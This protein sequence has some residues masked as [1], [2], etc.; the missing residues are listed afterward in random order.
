M[1][2]KPPW[3]PPDPPGPPGATSWPPCPPP[4]GPWPPSPPPPTPWPPAPWP[5]NPF[6]NYLASLVGHQVTVA[7][8]NGT[9]YTGLLTGV[10]SCYFITLLSCVDG[11]PSY[12][13]I[14]VQEIASVYKV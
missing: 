7:L 12:I 11:A 1:A 3:L 9:T 10:D 8:A 14:P 13:N 6:C 4:P 5:S 2:A